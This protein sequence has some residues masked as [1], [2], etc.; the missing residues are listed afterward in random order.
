MPTYNVAVTMTW[1]FS[2]KPPPPCPPPQGMLATGS[3]WRRRPTRWLRGVDGLK[4]WEV[5]V[6]AHEPLANQVGGRAC[7][8]AV[9]L[10]RAIHDGSAAGWV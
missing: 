4:D 1:P 5:E 9:G 6:Y 2:R 8:W 7:G 10:R 3:V